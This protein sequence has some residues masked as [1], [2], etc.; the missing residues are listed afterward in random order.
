MYRISKAHVREDVY[1]HIEGRINFTSFVYAYEEGPS[2]IELICKE[3]TDNSESILKNL[4]KI[5]LNKFFK[6]KNKIRNLFNS[7]ILPLTTDINNLGVPLSEKEKFIFLNK[8]KEKSLK[9]LKITD[10]ILKYIPN[11]KKDSIIIK[12]DIQE[13]IHYISLFTEEGFWIGN[14]KD[15]ILNKK[16]FIAKSKDLI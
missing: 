8:S 13:N 15:R 16:E 6:N 11:N 2:V 7:N 9:D 12:I 5:K 14:I 1:K 10:N 4:N 3:S